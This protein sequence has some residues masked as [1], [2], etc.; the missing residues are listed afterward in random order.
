MRGE[1]V[2]D[3]TGA[4]ALR[5]P[6]DDL[7]VAA[8]APFGAPAWCLA[9]WRHV[10]PPRARLAIVAVRDGPRL[11]AVAPM[12]G[13][14]RRTGVTT[15]RFL[16]TGAS[17]RGLPVAEPGSEAA[18]AAAIVEVLADL[19]DRPDVVAFDGVPADDPWPELLAGSWTARRAPWAHRHRSMPAPTLRLD[20]A[21]YE[22][23]LASR[24]RNFRSQ[25]GR[26]HRQLERAGASLRL[27]SDPD[28]LEDALG[29]FA[30]LHHRRWAGRGGSGVLDGRVEQMLRDVAADLAPLGRFR[31][32][33]LEVDGTPISCQIFVGAGGELAYWLGG[34][35][36]A[37]AQ[38]RPAL[39]T[40]VAALE[41]A[42]AVG[43]RRVDL[44]GGG[45]SYKYRLADGEEVLDWRVLVPPGPRR[46]VARATLAPRHGTRA[47]LERLPQD[48]KDRVKRLLGRPVST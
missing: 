28:D 10:A 2:E 22:S 45:Q 48:L 16:G 26:R 9:W 21:T 19:P 39:Q 38:Q 25:L 20:G 13:T 14:R 24:S 36:E 12:Y 42:W 4:E 34:F 40:I 33:V 37:W 8:G 29:A 18:A 15:Y 32:W 35:D 27:V 3:L 5:G 17:L 30:E 46:V 31:V 41:H 47:V 1:L 7:A 11:A 43:D 44:G 23:W 6:W